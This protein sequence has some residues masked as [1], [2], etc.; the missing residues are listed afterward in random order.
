MERLCHLPV[1]DV[2]TGHDKDRVGPDEEAA[3]LVPDVSPAERKTNSSLPSTSKSAMVSVRQLGLLM[4][5]QVLVG[6]P[7]VDLV[8]RVTSLQAMSSSG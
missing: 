2:G 6:F 5:A 3:L 4:P 8:S 1:L 7:A